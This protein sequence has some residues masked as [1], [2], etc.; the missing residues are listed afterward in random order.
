[1]RESRF[2][3]FCIAPALILLIFLLVAVGWAFYSSFTDIALVGR[4]AR[5][6]EFIGLR[7]YTR[8][9]H[10]SAFYN[11]LK[12]SFIFTIESAMIGQALLG[13]LLAVLFKQKSIKFKTAV[14]A[15]V[16]LCWVIPD[17]VAVYVWGA[18]TSRT[19]L[20]NT[21]LGWVGVSAINW[22]GEIPLETVT[23]ANIWRGTAFSMIL[24]SSALETIPP[25]YY[26]AA[27]VDGAS[28]WQKFRS[29]TLPLITP[30]ILID[31]ILI[32]MWTFGYFTLIYGLT[33]GGPG[34]L[35]EA[36]PVFIYNQSFRHYMIGYGAAL[37]FVMMIIVGSI[38]IIYFVLL[39]KAERMVY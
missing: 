7:N 3:V 18:L 21:I 12:I 13:L 15:A 32:T 6:P 4:A 39:R 20:L 31:L 27:D 14:A 37:S 34:H 5:L 9:F 36:F 29:I 22:L 38:C 26:E 33:G 28:S 24:F 2:I 17:I 23:I 16:T 11:S 1:M 25:H 8:I 30:T 35:T 10:D 19:G